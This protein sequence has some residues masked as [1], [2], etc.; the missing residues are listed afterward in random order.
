MLVR[1]PTQTP[2]CMGPSAVPSIKEQQDALWDQEGLN[3]LTQL[4]AARE[5]RLH[6]SCDFSISLSFL[7]VILAA[8]MS[9]CTISL[10]F[11]LWLLCPLS[12]EDE[13]D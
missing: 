7:I 12:P 3:W 4:S 10:F 8:T 1:P 13:Q 11:H 9:L 6:N 5:P 2:S